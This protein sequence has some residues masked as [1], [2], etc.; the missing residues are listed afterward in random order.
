MGLNLARSFTWNQ[1]NGDA[2]EQLIT[3]YRLANKQPIV[4]NIAL[5]SRWNLQM[6]ETSEVFHL[7]VSFLVVRPHIKG[8]L[9]QQ[10]P[11]VTQ[12]S[13]K[14]SDFGGKKVRP[15][16][17]G[18]WPV[19][20]S[21]QLFAVD[22]LV[23][24]SLPNKTYLSET[25]TRWPTLTGNKATQNNISLFCCFYFVHLIHISFV[26]VVVGAVSHQRAVEE[27]LILMLSSFSTTRWCWS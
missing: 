2:T 25:K 26:V 24:T 4:N 1:S 21:R 3:C 27:A 6:F 19:S 17:T 15:G 5:I 10:L 11:E 18:N 23:T 7:V 20:T 13:L 12:V 8:A 22:C 16:Y 14:T 9:H